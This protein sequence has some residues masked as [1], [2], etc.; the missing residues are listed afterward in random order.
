MISGQLQLLS[1]DSTS[2]LCRRLVE[3]FIKNGEMEDSVALAETVVD[4]V[5]ET[6]AG[7]HKEVM[8]CGV[9][10]QKRCYKLTRTATRTLHKFC[11]QASNHQKI[12]GM[13]I[14]ECVNGVDERC[15]QITEPS[16]YRVHGQILVEVR[17]VIPEA[18]APRKASG[19]RSPQEL[20]QDAKSFFTEPL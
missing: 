6:C 8:Q 9:G 19:T 10:W 11:S 18:V 20:G 13:A 2:E 3:A 16:P 1:K 7:E 12:D 14:A 4:D 5:S 15:E 17:H